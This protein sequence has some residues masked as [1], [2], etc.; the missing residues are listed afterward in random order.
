MGPAPA[1]SAQGNKVKVIMATATTPAART[2]GLFMGAGIRERCAVD[3]G[4][5]GGTG[6]TVATEV[7][8]GNPDLSPPIHA[9]PAD[10]PL[11]D[12][13]ADFPWW[14]DAAHQMIQ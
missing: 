2:M 8:H 7:A 12:G 6:W 1:T 11:G 5:W 9:R 10:F 3:G 13:C 4:W 14:G